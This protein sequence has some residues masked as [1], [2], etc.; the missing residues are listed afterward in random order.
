MLEKFENLFLFRF[1]DF[2]IKHTTKQ[3]T[4]SKTKEK[5]NFFVVV[6]K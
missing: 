1:R 2:C 3:K 5:L 4:L 6:V